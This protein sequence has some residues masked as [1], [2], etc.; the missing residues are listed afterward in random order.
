MKPRVLYLTS[1]YSL[2]NGWGTCAVNWIEGLRQD[3]AH[4]EILTMTG[5]RNDT[6]PWP[7][8]SIL[9]SAPDG[10]WKS[11]AMAWDGWQVARHCSGHFDI[12]HSLIEPFAPL[13]DRL[14]KRFGGK[15][16]IQLIGTYS[17]T[18]AR[19]SWRGDYLAA[20]RRAQNLISISHF[21]RRRVLE[22][23]PSLKI[24][25][26]HLGVDEKKFSAAAESTKLPYFLFVGASKPR[27]G[28]L[29]ALE[30]F[31][32]FRGDHPDFEFRIAGEMN[33]ADHYNE[34]V[35]AFIRKREIPVVFLGA[36]PHEELVRQLQ[37]CTAHV[38][39]SISEPFCF[40]GFGLVH[41][42]A[43]L[44]GSLT[45]GTKG[46]ANEEIIVAGKSGFLIPQNNPIALANAM[47]EAVGKIARDAK[48]VQQKCVEHARK[49]PWEHSV[50]SIRQVY[51]TLKSGK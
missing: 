29:V 8:H 15:S 26:A 31:S 6:A 34:K 12:V 16:M 49:F 36:L 38:L 48:Q 47:R 28:L 22:E 32:D 41:L 2:R 19:T 10:C 9:R 13:G 46:S 11:L 37:S 43:N 51:S 3:V 42:E 14:A 40:E 23:F 33:Q 24:E 7:V 44:C 27:K 25:V 5:A 39:P 4:A 21:T 20:Y 35:R 1:E 50:Q 17:V 45:I 18:P 30:A